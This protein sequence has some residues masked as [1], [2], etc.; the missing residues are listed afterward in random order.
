VR[1]RFRWTDYNLAKIARHRLSQR[2]VEYAW[3]HR[4]GDDGFRHPRGRYYESFGPCP[5]GRI[6]KIVWRWLPGEDWNEVE[7][8]YVITAYGNWRKR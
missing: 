6:I 1:V 2:E 4:H 8:V 5:S 3:A 7:V